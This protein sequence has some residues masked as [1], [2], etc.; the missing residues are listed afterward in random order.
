[1]LRLKAILCFALLSNPKYA[2]L[3]QSSETGAGC[4]ITLRHWMAWPDGTTRVLLILYIHVFIETKY[5]YT[6]LQIEFES[7]LIQ[8]CTVL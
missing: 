7:E 1:M 4:L 2:P 3:P 8:Y 6:V 5:T